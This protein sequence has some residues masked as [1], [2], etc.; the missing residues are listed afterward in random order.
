MEVKSENSENKTI[1]ARFIWNNGF[2]QAF[3][4]KKKVEKKQFSSQLTQKPASPYSCLEA[5]F[6]LP[7]K[8]Y[9]ISRINFW[10]F[11]IP[12]ANKSS[13]PLPRFD[14]SRSGSWLSLESLHS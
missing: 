8:D 6:I 7:L 9:I 12:A 14:T 2:S 1:F 4:L 11:A 10:V 3:L 5:V 13:S